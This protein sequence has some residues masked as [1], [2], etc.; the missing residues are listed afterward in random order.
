MLLDGRRMAV[1][2]PRV[3]APHRAAEHGHAAPAQV[4]R[5]DAGILANDGIRSAML[6]VR[7]PTGVSHSPDEWA[8]ADDCLDGIAALTEAVT[9]LAGA[10]A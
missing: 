4:R 3:V 1:Q 8:S 2:E 5:H 7:N 9:D 10:G 6:F